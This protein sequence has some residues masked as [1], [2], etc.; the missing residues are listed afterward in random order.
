MSGP[1]PVHA[2]QARPSVHLPFLVGSCCVHPG[3]LARPDSRPWLWLISLASCPC[4][5]PS[6]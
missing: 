3:D 5:L 6:Q 2:L 1:R 4:S